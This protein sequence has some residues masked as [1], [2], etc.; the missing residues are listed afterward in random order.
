[1]S[2][3]DDLKRAEMKY[4][5]DQIRKYEYDKNY[6]PL[7]YYLDG[8][9]AASI[10]IFDIILAKA[11]SELFMGIKDDERW[12]PS[13]FEK[14]AITIANGTFIYPNA[15]TTRN[16]D[17]G[18]LKFYKWWIDEKKKINETPNGQIFRKARNIGM[19]K[20]KAWEFSQD[21]SGTFQW[22]IIDAPGQKISDLCTDFYQIL[23]QFTV[24]AGTRIGKHKEGITSFQFLN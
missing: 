2:L 19:H 11:S 6:W 12:Y 10:S 15:S 14:I 18:P 1:M 5:I 9:L 17:D 7:I 16:S 22:W 21:S 23:S 24:D 8:F 13:N 3:A 20:N 4:F